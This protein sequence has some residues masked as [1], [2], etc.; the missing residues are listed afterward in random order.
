[1]DLKTLQLKYL[2]LIKGRN[3]QDEDEDKYFTNLYKSKNLE[4]L[5]DIVHFWRT[6]AI[7]EFCPTSSALLKKL[8]S[9]DVK[10]KNF[11]K[12]VKYSNY[13]EEF[14][15]TFLSYISED[16]NGLVT[17][18]A[19]FELAM[20]KVKSG[21]GKDY[22]IET[23]YDIYE[24]FNYILSDEKFPNEKDKGF[25]IKVSDSLENSFCV[26]NQN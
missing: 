4:I 1:M 3:I 13:I 2:D 24:V 21:S 9:F 11:Y 20:I 10:I 16:E 23:N 12:T 18:I 15:R 5:F 14:G 8:G 7:E 19:K 22:F 25:V 26:I 6:Q 17:F